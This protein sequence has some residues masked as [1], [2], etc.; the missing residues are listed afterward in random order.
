MK[1]TN[2]DAVRTDVRRVL[3][4]TLAILLVPAVAMRFTD[5]VNWGPGDFLVG[6]ALLAGTGLAYVLTK[7]RIAGRPGRLLLG[8]LLALGLLLV[9]AELAVGIFH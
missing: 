2:V 8:V 6:G 3:L 5:E 7:R 1:T 9:W 4:A